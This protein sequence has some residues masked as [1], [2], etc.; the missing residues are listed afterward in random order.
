MYCTHPPAVDYSRSRRSSDQLFRTI[1]FWSI[2]CCLQLAILPSWIITVQNSRKHL[3]SCIQILLNGNKIPRISVRPLIESSMGSVCGPMKLSMHPPWFLGGL[4]YM[5]NWAVIFRSN[6]EE[7]SMG[8]PFTPPPW[9]QRGYHCSRRPDQLSP[10]DRRYNV[11]AQSETVSQLHKHTKVT[12]SKVVMCSKHARG[13][14]YYWY[15]EGGGLSEHE[16]QSN[17]GV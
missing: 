9:F 11:V 7:W 4:E 8:G 6:I 14:L 15:V 17:R 1:L 13:Y 2:L 5:D 16:P 10:N 3:V 12:V